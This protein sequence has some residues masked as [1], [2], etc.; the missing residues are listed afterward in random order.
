MSV[1]V[2]ARARGVLGLINSAEPP[3]VYRHAPTPPQHL[4]ISLWMCLQQA[5]A[6]SNMNPNL[7]LALETNSERRGSAMPGRKHSG[8]PGQV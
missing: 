8:S 7:M 6:W 3:L 5:P 1:C 4:S 2:C